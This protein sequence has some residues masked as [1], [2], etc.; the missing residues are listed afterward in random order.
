[1]QHVTAGGMLP[2]NKVPFGYVIKMTPGFLCGIN[3][4][5]E[6]KLGVFLDRLCFYNQ[7]T[8][9]E[10]AGLFVAGGP[11]RVFASSNVFFC[12]PQNGGCPAHAGDNVGTLFEQE[13]K[14]VPVYG[15]ATV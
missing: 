3:P 6:S 2:G 14:S 7:D 5:V 10:K 15:N 4:G 12:L 11:Y 1:M 8:I 9:F 13:T